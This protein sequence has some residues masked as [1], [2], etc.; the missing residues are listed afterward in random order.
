M[1]AQLPL[2]SI[3][4]SLPRCALG[5]GDGYHQNWIHEVSSPSLS[6]TLSLPSPFF[7]PVRPLL[8]SRAPPACPVVCPRGPARS[9]AP[10]PSP[11]APARA[12]ARAARSRARDLS[13]RGA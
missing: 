12:P 4:L 7:F 8:P 1:R 9:V 13:V 11:A 3:S 5:L 10:R 2:S 6:L